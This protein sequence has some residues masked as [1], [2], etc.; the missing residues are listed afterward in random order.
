MDRFFHDPGA[1]SP[2]APSQSR[3]LRARQ[4]GRGFRRLRLRARAAWVQ[5]VNSLRRQCRVAVRFFRRKL[6]LAC[7]MI[8]GNLI[9]NRSLPV[10]ERWEKGRFLVPE[11]M[12][13]GPALGAVRSKF[14]GRTRY[15]GAGTRMSRRGAVIFAVTV[16]L[17]IAMAR[18]FGIGI[19]VSVGARYL[20]AVEDETVFNRAVALA[21]DRAGRSLG[22]TYTLNLIPTYSLGMVRSDELM[23]AEQMSEKLFAEINEVQPLY[24]LTVDGETVGAVA[25]RTLVDEYLEL[26]LAPY[27][28][29]EPNAEIGFAED[30]QFALRSVSIKY[31]MEPSALIAKL[32]GNR[33]AAITYTMK[34]GDTLASVA[35]ANNMTLT[36]LM[37]LN[38]GLEADNVSAGDKLVLN[39]SVPMLNVAI[40]RLETYDEV[41]PFTEK[42]VEDS[43]LY[44]GTTKI[45]QKGV[46]GQ[47]HVTAYRTYV[48]GKVVRVDPLEETILK[49]SVDQIVRVGT[50]KRKTGATGVLQWP[51][52][53]VVSSVFGNRPSL[54]DFHTGIDISN[55]K[56]T[57][58]YAS[59]GGEVVT[60]KY[61]NY[62]YGYH[63]IIK[64]DNTGYETLYAH[65]SEILVKVGDRVAKGQQIAK[66]G[67]TGRAYGNHCHFEVRING[68][69]VDP[70]KYVK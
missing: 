45:K 58:I 24:V 29:T 37:A 2:L 40:R 10:A 31:Y 65:C 15:R 33:K 28:T 49:E 34:T 53:G 20:G 67:A 38:E 16:M 46:N 64:H 8:C 11:G 26:Q 41:I 62:S 23:T 27:S 14:F 25:D 22:R 48:N 13:I 47:K 56:G 18:F 42:E 55:K 60:V 54:K 44:V 17:V 6:I 50:K 12:G 70:S 52:K 39:E 9:P 36:E 1:S 35:V 69:K 32:S 21:E 61:L 7:M 3:D 43:K 5:T 68:K 4:I 66:M 57:P 63:V 59:D 51:C 19:H 30:V